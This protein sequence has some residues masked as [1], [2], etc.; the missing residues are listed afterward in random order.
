MLPLAAPQRGGTAASPLLLLLRPPT[1]AGAGEKPP[2]RRGRSCIDPPELCPSPRLTFSGEEP[3][4]LP[5]AGGAAALPP[6]CSLR[7]GG[8]EQPGETPGAGHDGN[9]AAVLRAAACCTIL[10]VGLQAACPEPT[11]NYLVP[12][13]LESV[14]EIRLLPE[15][16]VRQ[17]AG[18]AGLELPC[19]PPVPSRD[20]RLETVTMGLW[21]ESPWAL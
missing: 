14:A 11:L 16:R 21:C 5:A 6:G 20:L 13:L 7:Q 1:P 19:L 3:N 15:F 18:Q 9:S 2:V 4:R 12:P 10:G 17:G 8:Q